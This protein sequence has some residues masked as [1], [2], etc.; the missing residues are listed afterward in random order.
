L[1]GKSDFAI[2]LFFKGQYITALIDAEYGTVSGLDVINNKRMLENETRHN[3]NNMV[4]NKI[5]VNIEC[6]IHNSILIKINNEIIIDWSPKDNDTIK[7][8]TLWQ[9]KSIYIG[10]Y[11][12]SFIIDNFV[13]TEIGQ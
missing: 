6:I 5:P 10:S 11:K 1:S 2:G 3:Q 7:Q 8:F 9:G 13:L 4:I 12:S